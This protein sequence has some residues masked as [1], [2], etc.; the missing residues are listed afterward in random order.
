MN[1]F[2]VYPHREIQENDESIILIGKSI[3]YYSHKDE[4]AFFEWI[5]RI[6]CIDKI[7]GV[8]CEL[9]FYIACDDLH[10]HDLRDL[11][12]LFYRYGLDMKQ[13]RRF[14]NKN[15]K[16]WFFENEKAY[17]HRGV[18]GDNKI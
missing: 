13:L 7:V 4:D 18:F 6:N 17:W 14:L 11:L 8:G 10:E 3:K 12:A 16:E 5:K 1:H 9:H 2:N 15:N